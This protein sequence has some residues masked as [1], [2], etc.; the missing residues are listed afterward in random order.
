MWSSVI[1][2]CKTNVVETDEGC[3][4]SSD[5]QNEARIYHHVGG[6]RMRNV[7]MS[8]ITRIV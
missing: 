5:M 2:C 6:Q 4:A 7:R 1:C 3:F 8:T